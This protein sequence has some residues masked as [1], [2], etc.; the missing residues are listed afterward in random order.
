MDWMTTKLKAGRI[1]PA[2]S[3]T[4]SCVAALQTIEL[5]KYL[6][7][8]KLDKMRNTFINLA[9]PMIQ[10][11]EPGEVEKIKIH[12]NLT[13]N[14]WERWEIGPFDLDKVTVRELLT[15][16]EEKYKINVKILSILEGAQI[17]S[18]LVL[19]L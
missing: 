3:T 11:G 2:L 18:D 17:Y 4:T 7:K 15:A 9:V 13:T 1:T 12:E 5:I 6:K 10:A 16:I 8:C 19:G 14:I